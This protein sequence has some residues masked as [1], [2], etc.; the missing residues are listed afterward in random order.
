MTYTRLLDEWTDLLERR[1]TFREPLAGYGQILQAWARWPLDRILPL[2]WTGDCSRERWQ[3]E[4][5]LL[6]EASPS[7]SSNDLEDLIAP[8]MEFLMAVGREDEALRR[9]ANAWDAGAIGPGDLFPRP[10]RIGALAVQEQTGLSQAFLSFLAYASLRPVLDA[11]FAL[12]RSHLV[13]SQWN[14]GVCPLC[15][16]PP[17]FADLVEDGRR[18]LACHFCG[19]EWFFSRLQ[20]PHC[21]TTNSKD[22]VQFQAEDREEGYMFAAC[23]RCYGYVKE[24]DRR[25][26]WN[27]GSALIEDW[28]S[29]HLDLIAHRSEYWRAIPT[30]IDLEK[31]E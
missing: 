10:G 29:P 16:A 4:V 26:R 9:F 22:L 20:C 14:L 24:V 21:G 17:A 30:L 8:V 11:H 1:P 15:G 12:C 6:S 19:G 7:V 5:P 23:K 13:E 2:R 18:R 28:G 25:L 27:A 3:R 31:V